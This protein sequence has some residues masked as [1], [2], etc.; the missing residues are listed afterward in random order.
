MVWIKLPK[1]GKPM[2]LHGPAPA[3]F[4]EIP[5]PNAKPLDPEPEPE[6]EKAEAEQKPEPDPEPKKSPAKGRKT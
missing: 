4:V 6:L 5:D 3:G 2:F 1:S